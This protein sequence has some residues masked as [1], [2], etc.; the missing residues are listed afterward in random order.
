MPV[1][2]DVPWRMYFREEALVGASI[3]VKLPWTEAG[4]QAIWFQQGILLAN[5]GS[6]KTHHDTPVA[7]GHHDASPKDGE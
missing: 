1:T 4:L 6:I 2:L 3:M 7:D 5:V